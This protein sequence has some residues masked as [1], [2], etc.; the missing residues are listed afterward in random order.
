[1]TNNGLST[2][3]LGL[4]SALLVAA[5][6]VLLAVAPARADEISKTSFELT[7]DFSRFDHTNVSAG[8]LSVSA[9]HAYGTGSYGARASY[10]GGGLDGFARGVF[11]V[12]WASGNDVWYD[13]AFYLPVGFKNAQSGKIDLMTWDNRPSNGADA[14]YGGITID[15]FDHRVRLVRGTY[16]TGVSDTLAG[17]FDVPEGR[18]FFVLVHQRLGTEN[19]LSEVYMDSNLIGRSTAPNTFGRP[20]ER[21]RYGLASVKQANPIELWFDRAIAIK[22]TATTGGGSGCAWSITDSTASQP[23][24]WPPACW[25]P[26]SNSSPFNSYIPTGA[27]VE[28][29]SSEIVQRLLGFGPVNDLRAGVADTS[30][31]FYHPVYYA[32]G[33]DPLYFVNG[34]S[35][36]EPYAVAGKLVHV[37]AGARPAGGSDHHFAVVDG[38]YEWGFWNARIDQA[39]HLITGAG[40]DGEALVGRKV[41]LSGDG[42][43]AACT[44]ARFPCLAGIIRAQELEAGQ[45]NH[46]LFMTVH[47]TDGRG[48]YPSDTTSK[49]ECGDPTDAPSM[50][51]RFQL[52]MSDAQID[53]LGAPQWKKTILKAMAHYGMYVGDVTES[54]WGLIFE[55]G[56][57][58]TS[59][60]VEDEMVKFAR[61]AGVPSY[62]DSSQGRSIYTFD[63]SSDIDWARYLRVIDP[64]VAEGTC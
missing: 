32:D 21:V 57:S 24:S 8:V 50:G 33:S 54:P 6:L 48:V 64:C 59:F 25:R 53:A 51:A 20:I 49:P 36:V 27:A 18:W 16:S 23:S 22:R 34:G 63:V 61:S 58:Y 30:S 5:V 45:I 46:A 55:S 41:A 47:C 42:Q 62:Y 44:A 12:S 29:R 9:E 7:R 52:A 35:S 26:F 1:M 28:Q 15:G 14:D 31:D 10:V 2:K 39:A 17:P 11:D 60:G 3:L 40:T 43:N 38:G 4:G 56:S 13:A 37:P 19:A